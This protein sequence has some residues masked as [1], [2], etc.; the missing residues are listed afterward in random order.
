TLII[1]DEEKVSVEEVIRDFESIGLDNMTAFVPV[2][3]IQ[4]FNRLESYKEDTSIE[5]YPHI[6]GGSV[7]VID[8][9]SKKEWEEGH[10]HDAIHIPLGNLF[11]QLDCIPKDCPVVLQCRTGLRS[12]IAASILQR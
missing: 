9:R 11:K 6:K 2:K 3:V 10:L 12:A 8:V 7:K 5:L 4:K 1:L